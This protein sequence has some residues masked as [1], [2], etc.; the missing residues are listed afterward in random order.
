MYE[1]LF[2]FNLEHKCAKFSFLT[3][4][5]GDFFNIFYSCDHIYIGIYVMYILHIFLF[6]MCLYDFL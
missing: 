5:A 1:V 3:D 6:R 2:S 4:T